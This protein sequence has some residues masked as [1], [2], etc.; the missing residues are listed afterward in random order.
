MKFCVLKKYI[1]YEENFMN[2]FTINEGV[3][4]KRLALLTMM[5]F[6]LMSVESYGVN[7]TDTV[8][9]YI[10]DQTGTAINGVTV[11]AIN[12]SGQVLTWNITALSKDYFLVVPSGIPIRIVPL[13]RNDYDFIPKE[14]YYPAVNQ[15]LINQNFKGYDEANPLGVTVVNPAKNAITSSNPTFVWNKLN[16]PKYYSIIISTLSTLKDTVY[17]KD[18]IPKIDTTFTIPVTLK[19]STT[20][21]FKIL[22]ITYPGSLGGV[23]RTGSSVISSFKTDVNSNIAQ[24]KNN[25][26]NINYRQKGNDINARYFDFRGRLISKSTYNIQNYKH[27]SMKISISNNSR[28]IYIGF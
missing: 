9:G 21:Y 2:Q 10:S 14:Y 16:V 4:M 3:F 24:T 13:P 27:H 7:G 25:P 15:K 28:R 26:F 22:S 5:V 11:Q 6:L 20:Y 17:I 19:S 12:S 1:N 18:S 23:K 8:S